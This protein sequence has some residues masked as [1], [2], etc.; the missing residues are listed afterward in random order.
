MRVRLLD[1]ARLLL[2]GVEAHAQRYVGNMQKGRN[3][4]QVEEGKEP[5]GFWAAVKSREDYASADYLKV[6]ASK[7]NK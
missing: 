1:L 3:L 6:R 4:V 7:N 5:D 2:F